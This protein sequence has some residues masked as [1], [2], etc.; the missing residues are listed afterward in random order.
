MRSMAPG[1][2]FS[3]ITSQV[4]ISLVKIS[5]PLSNLVFRVMLRLLLLSMV[6]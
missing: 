5:F 4:S 1:A 3:T 6:K 2:K